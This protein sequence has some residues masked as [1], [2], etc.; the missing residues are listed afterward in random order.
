MRESSGPRRPPIADVRRQQ[1]VV[2]GRLALARFSR[3]PEI[4]E[5]SERPLGNLAHTGRGCAHSS[6]RLSG[7]DVHEGNVHSTR[8]PTTFILM[9]SFGTTRS[10]SDTHRS[11]DS[12]SER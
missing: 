10:P 2:M 7:F 1:T 11:M 5:A 12:I 8:P 9:I 3:S 4:L 6:N